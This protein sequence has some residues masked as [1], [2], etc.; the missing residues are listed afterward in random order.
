MAVAMVAVFLLPSTFAIYRAVN[1]TAWNLQDVQS[2]PSQLLAPVISLFA[3]VHFPVRITVALL[4]AD[5]THPLA[6]VP[7]FELDCALIR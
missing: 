5:V 1:G 7:L 6:R 4:Q 2:S 3:V